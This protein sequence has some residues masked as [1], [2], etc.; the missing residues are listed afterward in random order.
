VQ[1]C[2]LCCCSHQVGFKV[3]AGEYWRLL[4]AAFVHGNVLHVGVSDGLGSHSNKLLV[5]APCT[6]P[7]AVPVLSPVC[8]LRLEDL[9]K[10]QSVHFTCAGFQHS[11]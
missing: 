1:C 5:L 9:H 3:A 11:Q 10:L 6:P 2:L 7:L 8:G 4:T